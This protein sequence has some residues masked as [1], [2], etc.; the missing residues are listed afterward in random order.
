MAY[1]QTKKE[2]V[3]QALIASSL[4]I[5]EEKVIKQKL[6][7]FFEK[8]ASDIKKTYDQDDTVP[9]AF[10]YENDLNKII[11]EH[12]VNVASKGS[13]VIRKVK[14]PVQSEK[15]IIN[16]IIKSLIKKKAKKRSDFSCKSILDTVNNDLKSYLKR[17][18]KTN[19]KFFNI[20]TELKVKDDID[21]DD[22]AP[23]GIGE[24]LFDMFLDTLE[25]RINL[26]AQMETAIAYDD[27]QESELEALDEINADF[28]D[29]TSISDFKQTKTW[30]A[31]LDDRT[32]PEHA[33]A[34][35]Q[36]VDID[37]PFIVGGEELMEPRD[38]SLG[39]SDWNIFGCRCEVIYNLV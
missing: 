35:G 18:E 8:V 30:I 17:I 27:G 24:D 5:K 29:D 6:R 16:H 3:Q 9:N 22:L 38:D 37:E 36:E 1:K 20:K 7:S 39:A 14:K 32:R 19:Q 2:K 31:I 11:T 12:F 15:D 4:K 34:D 28:D 10:N 25:S 26:I 13:S 21:F 23:R 33:E